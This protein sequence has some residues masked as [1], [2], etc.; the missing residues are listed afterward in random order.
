LKL[1]G[2][3]RLAHNVKAWFHDFAF[4]FNLYRYAADMDVDLMTARARCMASIK[5]MRSDHL[6]YTNPTPYKVSVSEDLY[7]FIHKLWLEEAP[8][9]EIV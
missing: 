9:G 6:R 3:N 5:M 2:F 7:A 4:K 8:V 1:P